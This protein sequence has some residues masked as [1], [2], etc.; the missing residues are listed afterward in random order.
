LF[1]PGPGDS[2]GRKGWGN[3]LCRRQ[4]RAKTFAAWSLH[5]HP[6]GTCHWTGPGGRAYARPPTDHRLD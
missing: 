6:D 3:D 1:E 2:I 5:R 4:H